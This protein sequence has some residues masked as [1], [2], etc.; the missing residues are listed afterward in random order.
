[1]FIKGH[2]IPGDTNSK[3]QI[4][5]FVS[6]FRVNNGS[7]FLGVALTEYFT[8]INFNTKSRVCKITFINSLMQNHFKFNSLK[9]FIPR[10]VTG[11]KNSPTVAHACRKRR[12]KWVL[13]AWRY[14]WATQSPRDI[15]METWSSRFGVGRGADDPHPGKSQQLGKLRCDLGTVRS[16]EMTGRSPLR[17]RRSALDW[18]AI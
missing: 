10:V 18:T 16:I 6:D 12:L 1:M 8:K 4:V 2:Q 9:S 3:D 15:N 17:R 11:E 13:V 7:G 5:K 14:N